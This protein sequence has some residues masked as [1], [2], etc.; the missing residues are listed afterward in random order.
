MDPGTERMVKVYV[1]RD[2][3]EGYFLKDLLASHGIESQ[4]VD[5]NSIYAGVGGIER[6]KVWVFEND[7]ETAR[8]L[9]ARY[10]TIKKETAR[11]TT[12]DS[13]ADDDDPTPAWKE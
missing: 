2:S 1:A 10:E 6:P 5:E 3:F 7:E 4:V 12:Q 13:E 11:E 8:E 9:I